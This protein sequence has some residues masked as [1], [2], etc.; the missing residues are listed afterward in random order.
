VAKR[1]DVTIGWQRDKLPPNFD[2]TASWRQ[3]RDKLVLR[4]P[5]RS[6]LKMK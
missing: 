6:G 2:K 4:T 3:P 1:H 5:G